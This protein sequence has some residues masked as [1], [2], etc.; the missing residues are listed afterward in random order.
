MKNLICSLALVLLS[1]LLV[2]PTDA[3]DFDETG[4]LPGGG[5][6]V[7][8]GDAPCGTG[9]GWWVGADLDGPGGFPYT[10]IAPGIGFPTG[11]QDVSV[12]WGP[13]QALGIGAEVLPCDPVPTVGTTWGRIK[14]LL[15]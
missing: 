8:R 5:A 15:R 14:A 12:L 13:T 2:T 4:Y 10:N 9:P 7:D 1:Q 6:V 3:A 11:W